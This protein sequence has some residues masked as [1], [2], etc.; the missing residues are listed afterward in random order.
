[1]VLIYD[2]SDTG[3]VFQW[4]NYKTICTYANE[5]TLFFIKRQNTTKDVSLPTHPLL[6]SYYQI[7]LIVRT[8]ILLVHPTRCIQHRP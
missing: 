7:A 6:I 1:M 3:Y 8:F 5:E 2:V 4:Q